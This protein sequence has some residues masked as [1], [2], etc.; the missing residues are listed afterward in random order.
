MTIPVARVQEPQLG[1][2]QAE[3]SRSRD[4]HDVRLLPEQESPVRLQSPVPPG[5]GLPRGVLGSVGSIPQIK[6]L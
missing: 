4:L 2:P 5:Q 6:E 3:Q 1:P